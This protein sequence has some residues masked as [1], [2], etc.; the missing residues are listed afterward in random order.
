[1]NIFKL[2]IVA[3][4]LMVGLSSCYRENIIFSTDPRIVRVNWAGTAKR[5]CANVSQ[6]AWSPDGTKIVSNGIR[7]VIWDAVTGARVRV[8]PEASAQVVWGATSIITVAR[9]TYLEKDIRVAVKFWN[10]NSGVLERSLSIAG[11]D[12][13]VSPDGTQG[14]IGALE[15]GVSTT[16]VVSLTD[17]STVRNLN[18]APPANATSASYSRFS[19]TSDGKRIIAAGDIEEL[20]ATNSVSVSVP[21]TPAVRV[22]SAVT[23][24]IERDFPGSLLSSSP[25]G[26][27]LLYSDTKL[28]NLETGTV[29]SL[30]RDPNPGGRPMIVLGWNSNGSQVHLTPY[31]IYETTEVWNLGTL[32]LEKTLPGTNSYGWNSSGA[33]ADTG[34]SAYAPNAGPVPDCNLKILDLTTLKTIRTLD[35]TGLDALEVKF[36]LNATYLTESEYGISGTAT[37]AGTIYQVRGKGNAG[38]RGRLLRQTP[39]DLLPSSY[40][41]LLDSG[42]AVVWHV[43]GFSPSFASIQKGPAPTY[44]YGF[45]LGINN[46]LDGYNLNLTPS[47]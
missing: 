25:D 12:L 10:P 35:E 31:G 20:K 28:L 45:G 13:T 22:W 15:N 1:M 19:W 33:P 43:L 24:E 5:V 46:N 14:L 47:P 40:L 39:A 27:T 21:V 23:G 3:A 41:E 6:T 9:P 37:V 7:T 36:A 34:V 18:V 42:G 17:G 32:K 38:T 29:R 30:N 26:K 11:A 16:R 44:D 4:A 8:I 2:V